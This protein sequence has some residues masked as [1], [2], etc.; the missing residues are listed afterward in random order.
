MKAKSIALCLALILSYVQLATASNRNHPLPHG[1]A[2]KPLTEGQAMFTTNPHHNWLEI[3]IPN[4]GEDQSFAIADISGK[5]LFVGTFK[6]GKALVDISSLKTGN[7]QIQ[8]E[9]NS[10]PTN[11]LFQ[12]L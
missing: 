10:L 6:K 4:H 7:Y 5:V 1:L 2:I 11:E 12:I 3:S 9:E 8:W